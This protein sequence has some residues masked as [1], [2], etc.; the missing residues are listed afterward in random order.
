MYLGWFKLQQVL[1]G[2]KKK[3]VWK[4][5]L[6][7]ALVICLLPVAVSEHP[8]NETDAKL[9]W[10]DSAG[11]LLCSQKGNPKYYLQ[12]F[13]F[14]SQTTGIANGVLLLHSMCIV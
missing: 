4:K 1:K 9:H 7:S 12:L 8:H 13:L 11:N 10:R 6:F 5:F 14:L 3:T 2:A